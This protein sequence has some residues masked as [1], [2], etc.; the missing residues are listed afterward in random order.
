MGKGKLWHPADQ[1]PLNRSSPN[2]IHV[3]TSWVLITKQ[4]LDAIGPG[5]SFPHI[6]DFD[7]FRI[8]AVTSN[9]EGMLN[10]LNLFGLRRL[11]LLSQF[12]IV[13]FYVLLFHVRTA[14]SCPVTWSVIFTS[15]YFIPYKMV[16][17]FHVQ[18]FHFFSAPGTRIAMR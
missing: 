11:P 15:C 12:H 14:V 4:N 3:I 6:R 17:Q 16:R 7:I 18:H 2:L 13:L 1:K 9:R 8:G 5:V 10:L